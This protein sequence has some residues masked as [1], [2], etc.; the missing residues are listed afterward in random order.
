MSFVA[1]LSSFALGL[2][3]GAAGGVVFGFVWYERK[4]GLLSDHSGRRAAAIRYQ[5]DDI[6]SPFAQ[7]ATEDVARY[8]SANAPLFHSVQWRDLG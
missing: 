1:L 7:E 8:Q 6:Y 4:C 2:C 3:V 5:L